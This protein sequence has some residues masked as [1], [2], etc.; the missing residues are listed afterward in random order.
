VGHPPGTFHLGRRRPEARQRRHYRGR[1][2]SHRPSGR[3]HGGTPAPHARPRLSR[4][5]HFRSCPGRKPPLRLLPGFRRYHGRGQLSGAYGRCVQDGGRALRRFAQGRARH[6]SQHGALRRNGV[7]QDCLWPHATLEARLRSRGTAQSR[8]HPER[9]SRGLPQE[10]E[11]AAS[12][13]PADR[14]LHRMRL[15]RIHLS[16]PQ[17]HHF[18]APAYRLAT[19][20]GSGG[21]PE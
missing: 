2:L 10:F 13:Q 12:G 1:G 6:R 14:P 17:L 7:G 4:G 16:F 21:G 15:L 18:A 5:D 3:G 19:A 20:H 8:C 11:T 9:R